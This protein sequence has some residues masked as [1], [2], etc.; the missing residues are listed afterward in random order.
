M[1]LLGH[2]MRRIMHACTWKSL[3]QDVDYTVVHCHSRLWS[4]VP[5]PWQHVI[6]RRFTTSCD[7]R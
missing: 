6:E 2:E 4:G 5:C 3:N 7:S 1:N